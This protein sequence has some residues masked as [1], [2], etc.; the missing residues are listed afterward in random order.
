MH[1]TAA[2]L[3][4]TLSSRNR[5]WPISRVLQ[6]VGHYFFEQSPNCIGEMNLAILMTIGLG[7]ERDDYAQHSFCQYSLQGC[8]LPEQAHVVQRGARPGLQMAGP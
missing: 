2:G 3:Y 1:W 5:K 4:D 8:G 6:N 7:H